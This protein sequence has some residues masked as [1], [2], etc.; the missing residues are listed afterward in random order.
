[1]WP[2]LEILKNV[3]TVKNIPCRQLGTTEGVREKALGGSNFCLRFILDSKAEDI[4]GER[5][6]NHLLMVEG[7]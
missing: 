2:I 6:H 7:V 3:M 4:L 1:M 5:G